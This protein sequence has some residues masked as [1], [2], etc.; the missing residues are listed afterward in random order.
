MAVLAKEGTPFHSQTTI[1]IVF[2][3]AP[4]THNRDFRHTGPGIASSPKPALSFILTTLAYK[5]PNHRR[6][7]YE[8]FI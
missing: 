4:H 3:Y 8:Q 5:N 2:G 6:V 7:C 1:Y